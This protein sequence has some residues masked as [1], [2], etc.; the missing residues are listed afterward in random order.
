MADC[1]VVTCVSVLVLTEEV[2]SLVHGSLTWLS[3]LLPLPRPLVTRTGSEE[4]W[5]IDSKGI[6]VVKCPPRM[7]SERLV[8][9]SLDLVVSCTS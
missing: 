8:G 1:T 5:G 9:T 3:P 2:S 4:L 7:L 6:F